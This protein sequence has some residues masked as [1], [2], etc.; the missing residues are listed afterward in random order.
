MKLRPQSRHFRPHL[1]THALNFPAHPLDF[2]PDELLQVLALSLGG[3]LVF[4]ARTA[5][6]SSVNPTFRRS[7]AV[8]SVSVMGMV[9]FRIAAGKTLDEVNPLPYDDGNNGCERLS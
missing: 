6:C 1:R 3:F 5:A 4:F 7:A 9:I 8:F 2:R